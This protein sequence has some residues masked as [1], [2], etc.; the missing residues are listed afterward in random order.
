MRAA[1]LLLA[2][3]APAGAAGPRLVSLNPCVDAVLA[4]VADPDQIAGVSHYSQDPAATSVD[5]RWARRFPA[6]MNQRQLSARG[7][8]YANAGAFDDI[9]QSWV[10]K[11]SDA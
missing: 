11:L 5:V 3:A 8:G 4:A 10:S 7:S 1:A 9:A 2:L 6:P